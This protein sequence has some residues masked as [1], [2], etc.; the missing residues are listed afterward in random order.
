[1]TGCVSK[2]HYLQVDKNN[3]TGAQGGFFPIG[4]GWYRKTFTLPESFRDKRVILRLDGV[5][6]YNTL[7]KNPSR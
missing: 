4:A 3:A 6:I 1:M 7:G 2:M 5:M